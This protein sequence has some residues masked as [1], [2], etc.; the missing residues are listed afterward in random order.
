MRADEFPAPV[1]D[2]EAEGLPGVADD[3]STAWDE[4][5]SGR[6]ADGPDPGLLPIDRDERPLGLDHYGTTARE[7]LAGEPLDV[8]LDREVPDTS[9]DGPGAPVADLD[10]IDEDAVEDM[11]PVQVNRDSAVSV[12]D[13]GTGRGTV[14]R[15][16]AA[17]DAPGQDGIAVDAGPAGGGASAEEAALHEVP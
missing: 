8:K 10:A 2:P 14:G 12:Y 5:E 6:I 17:E 16:V 15:L 4:V 1:S 3:D 11:P 7:A 9:S 13:M